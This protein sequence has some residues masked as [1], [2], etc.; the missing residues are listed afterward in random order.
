MPIDRGQEILTITPRTAPPRMKTSIHERPQHAFAAIG[1]AAL[2][3]ISY[4]LLFHFHGWGVVV[5]VSSATARA[6]VADGTTAQNVMRL[7]GAASNIPIEVPRS[8]G[9]A[10]TVAGAGDTL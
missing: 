3:D 9:A 7:T 8:A 1:S 2:R 4:G 6:I 5:G 10:R